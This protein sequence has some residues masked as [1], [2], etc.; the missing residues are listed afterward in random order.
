MSTSKPSSEDSE[1]NDI[2][3]ALTVHDLT[4]LGLGEIAYIRSVSDGE[5]DGFGVFAANGE[6]LAM[7]ANFDV[8]K[9]AAIQHDLAPQNT[10]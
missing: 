3:K 9:A 4:Y 2:P 10:H 1:K 8:A 7:Y 6:P 5:H